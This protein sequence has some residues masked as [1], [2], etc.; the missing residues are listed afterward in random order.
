MKIEKG[1]GNSNREIY[2]VLTQAYLTVS[3]C[4][5]ECVCTRIPDVL[6]GRKM[7]KLVRV[8]RLGLLSGLF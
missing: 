2:C 6:S 3:V 8:L 5:Q 4:V 1:R 7:R